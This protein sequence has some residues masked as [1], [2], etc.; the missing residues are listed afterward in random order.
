MAALFILPLIPLFIGPA[1]FALML[2]CWGLG[3]KDFLYR[4]TLLL[5]GSLVTLLP[6]LAVAGYIIRS[7]I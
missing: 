6:A 3:F 1:A 7:L 5:F 2:F 4:Q